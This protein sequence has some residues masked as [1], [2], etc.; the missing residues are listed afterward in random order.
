MK[1]LQ[2]VLKRALKEA[3]QRKC[4]V[5]G[6]GSQPITGWAKFTPI[7]EFFSPYGVKVEKVLS[8]R[9]EAACSLFYL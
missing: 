6:R 9:A 1:G 2:S 8:E 4:C 5:I 7:V 3:R